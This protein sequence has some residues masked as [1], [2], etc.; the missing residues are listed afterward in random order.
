MRRLPGL[1]LLRGLPPASASAA[2]PKQK[3]VVSLQGWPAAL[4]GPAQ[5]VILTPPESRPIEVSFGER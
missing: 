1:M 3:V 4:D 5:T 2:A